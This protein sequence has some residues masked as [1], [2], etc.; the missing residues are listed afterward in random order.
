[1]QLDNLIYEVNPERNTI[2]YYAGLPPGLRSIALQKLADHSQLYAVYAEGVRPIHR[3]QRAEPW[4]ISG[5]TIGNDITN[6]AFRDSVY[7]MTTGRRGLFGAIGFGAPVAIC[8]RSIRPE[9]F[10][11]QD[12]YFAVAGRFI[13]NM[14]S[15]GIELIK[16]SSICQTSILKK[17]EL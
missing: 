7:L 17:N 14:R 13:D 4:I 3:G 12:G 1:L 15:W 5:E 16:M 10:D 2:T 9:I 8:P 11:F 6:L